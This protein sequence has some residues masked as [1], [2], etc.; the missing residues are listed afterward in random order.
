MSKTQRRIIGLASAATA[1]LC[2][3][4]CETLGKRNRAPEGYNPQAP[5]AHFSNKLTPPLEGDFRV[6]YVPSLFD[7]PPNLRG[8]RH[9]YVG[10]LIAR[11]MALEGLRYR[12]SATVKYNVQYEYSTEFS[13]AQ[14]GFR[15]EFEIYI[16]ER[17]SSDSLNRKEV[18][19]GSAHIE[20]HPSQDI[21]QAFP[22]F[23][24]VLL[25]GFPERTESINVR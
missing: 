23:L 6:T 5:T 24:S 12:E 11:R 7:E 17:V 18:W 9:E 20:G 8:K 15:H 19:R 16:L 25:N 13:V 3:A 14:Q 1:V 10:T 4:S 22:A 21:A 2:F